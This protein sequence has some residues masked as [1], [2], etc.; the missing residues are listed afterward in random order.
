MVFLMKKYEFILKKNSF[1]LLKYWAAFSVMF[2]HY[3][4]YAFIEAEQAWDFMDR[5]RKISEFFPGVIVLFT[6]SGFLISNSM[7]CSKSKK[8]F[9]KKRIFRLYPE[10]WLCTLVNLGV[11]LIIAREYMDKKIVLWI[12]TQF[13]GIANTPSSLNTFATG[14]VNGAL[15]TIFVEVQLYIIVCIGYG[16]L[17]KI[18]IFHWSILLMVLAGLNLCCDYIARKQQNGLIPKLIERSFFPY[19]IWFMIGVFCYRYRRNIIGYLRYLTIPMLG[20]YRYV[21][22]NSAGQPGYYKGIGISILCPFIIIGLAYLLPT[23]RLKRDLCYGMFLYHWIVL[24]IIVK[25]KLL[26]KWKWY[27]CLIFFILTTLLLAYLSNVIIKKC[28]GLIDKRKKE[29]E[30]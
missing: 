25:F 27:V 29:V 1:D 5:L 26:D 3:T 9:I 13:F 14:S 18:N 20:I 10:L 19:A 21:W 24:N 30:L 2:L 23:I 11:L 16:K 4:Y 22:I 17:K 28:L 8:E 15:W 7:E 6:I 12:V